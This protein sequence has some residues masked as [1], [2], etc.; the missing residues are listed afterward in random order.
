MLQS[1]IDW[2]LIPDH[3]LINTGLAI[4]HVENGIWLSVYAEWNL[5]EISDVC[6]YASLISCI[7]IHLMN[8]KLTLLS[9]LHSNVWSCMQYI[10]ST[11][12]SLISYYIIAKKAF[13]EVI[14]IMNEFRRGRRSQWVCFYT[15]KNVINSQLLF[16]LTKYV[17]LIQIYAHILIRCCVI[18]YVCFPGM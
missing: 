9:V 5:P 1:L 4:L 16:L 6:N 14:I 12:V 3:H 2:S 10:F 11:Y 8:F 17:I 15:P 13:Q 18:Y 7:K